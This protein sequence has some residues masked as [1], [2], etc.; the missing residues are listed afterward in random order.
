MDVLPK[1]LEAFGGWLPEKGRTDAC[2]DKNVNPKLAI[3]TLAFLSP[4]KTAL[5]GYWR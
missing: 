5:F 2:G 4:F 3:F 1:A